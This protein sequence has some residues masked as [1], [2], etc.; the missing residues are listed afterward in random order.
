[1]ISS[2]RLYASARIL[3]LFLA[4]VFLHEKLE[5]TVVMAANENKTLDEELPDSATKNLTATLHHYSA[6]RIIIAARLQLYQSRKYRPEQKEQ[7]IEG[8]LAAENRIPLVP[9]HT[10]QI[11]F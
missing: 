9:L 4:Q 1:M 3:R 6:A 2:L 8:L 10:S 7:P 5:R 11:D